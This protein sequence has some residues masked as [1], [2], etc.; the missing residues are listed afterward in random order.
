MGLSVVLISPQSAAKSQN[1]ANKFDL[2]MTFLRDRGNIAAKQLGILHQWG[3]PMGMQVLGYD[4][5]TVMPTVILTDERGTIVYSDQ[6]DN[7]RVRPEPGIFEALL[8]TTELN[9]K[10]STTL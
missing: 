6:T 4:S 10:T 2:P 9:T 1:L 7:Y 3:T 5:D 8:K